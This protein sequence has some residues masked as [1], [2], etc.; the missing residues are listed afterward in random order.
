MNYAGFCIVHVGASRLSSDMP[1]KTGGRK[2]RELM[3]PISLM[4][5]LFLFATG[6]A[7]AQE[8]ETTKPTTKSSSVPKDE[9]DLT[10]SWTYQRD[11]G[12][13]D[14]G[15][16]ELKR[17]TTCDAEDGWI[18]YSGEKRNP[19]VSKTRFWVKA[20]AV[21]TELG[22]PAAPCVGGVNQAGEIVLSCRFLSTSLG[23]LTAKRDQAGTPKPA[24]PTPQFS[25]KPI[26][27]SDNSISGDWDVT[28]SLGSNTF[29]FRIRITLNGEKAVIDWTAQNGKTTTFLGAW[30]GNTL[31]MIREQPN[32]RITDTVTLQGEKLI[33]DTNVTLKTGSHLT[34]KWEANR[35]GSESQQRTE[36]PVF[37][38][39]NDVAQAPKTASGSAKASA[40]SVAELSAEGYRDLIVNTA[41]AMSDMRA[42]AQITSGTGTEYVNGRQ[43]QCIM[44]FTVTEATAQNVANRRKE[45]AS[46]PVPKALAASHAEI[47]KWMKSA[48]ANAKLVPRCFEPL[49]QASAEQY[50]FLRLLGEYDD[51]RKNAATALKGV[52][53]TLPPIEKSTP[54]KK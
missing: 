37:R 30:D 13:G 4:V 36:E 26:R 18:C 54:E 38:G 12:R 52:G 2:M 9:I 17:D 50:G 48:E 14:K 25:E 28:V 32:A 1:F 47:L 5:I 16:F 3:I 10:G 45:W 20:K 33:G 27:S 35:I 41:D 43:R 42:Y 22:G 15:T 23:T 24:T 46:A 53:V 40:N 6:T 51:L 49:L 44:T 8:K 11:D 34:G 39:D 31:T 19:D 29:R 21:R 7:D